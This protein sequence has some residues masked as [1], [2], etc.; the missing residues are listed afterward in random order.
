MLLERVQVHPGFFSII[1]STTPLL[2][3]YSTFLHKVS[4]DPTVSGGIS[5]LYKWL[6]YIL[7][8]K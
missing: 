5:S 1:F 2:V 8:H 3:R 6:D 4:L 7:W